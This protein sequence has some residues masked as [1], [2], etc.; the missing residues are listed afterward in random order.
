MDLDTEN[1]NKK[2]TSAILIL[3]RQGNRS[4]KEKNKRSD[5]LVWKGD[6]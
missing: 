3:I 1:N 2:N 4:V 5:L 6:P